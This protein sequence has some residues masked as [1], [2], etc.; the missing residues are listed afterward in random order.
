MNRI[1]STLKA[2][3][4]LKKHNLGSLRNFSSDQATIFDKVI[5][6][7]I[8]AEIVYEDSQILAFKDIMPQAPVH[9]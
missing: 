8:P 4:P 2:I 6:R 9:V 3:S 1:F 5:S 7:E